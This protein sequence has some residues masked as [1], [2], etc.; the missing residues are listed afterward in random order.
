MVRWLP[1]LLVGLASVG[2]GSKRFV[3]EERWAEAPEL[4][5]AVLRHGD[6][7][8]VSAVAG[9]TPLKLDLEADA[10]DRGGTEIWLFAYRRANLEERFP[11]LVGADAQAMLDALSPTADPEGPKPHPRTRCFGD[12]R[13]RRNQPSYRSKTWENA[14]LRPRLNVRPRPTRGFEVERFNSDTGT[15]LDGLPCPKRAP[16]VLRLE[17][18]LHR[19]GHGDAEP[20]RGQAL[21]EVARSRRAPSRTRS[22]TTPFHARLGGPARTGDPPQPPAALC[23]SP[24]SRARRREGLASARPGTAR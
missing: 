15:H 23:R 20:L 22:P 1:W 4:R 14:A 18:A 19:Y 7:L 21:P 2:C 5:V 10:P 6:Q 16:G 9:A 8:R 17:V 12:P 3:A 11:G 13:R 24:S